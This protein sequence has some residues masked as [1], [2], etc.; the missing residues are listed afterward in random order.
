M[1]ANLLAKFGVLAA[2]IG[3]IIAIIIASGSEPK[4]KQIKTDRL[5]IRCKN[6]EPVIEYREK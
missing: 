3:P 4:T 1:E 6:G 5:T 2:I